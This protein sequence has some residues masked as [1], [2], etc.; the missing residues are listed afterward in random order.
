MFYLKGTRFGFPLILR[1]GV[2]KHHETY[3]IKWNRHHGAEIH[4][5]LKGHISWELAS[6]PCPLT[7]MG[8][9]FTVIT[10][11]EKHRGLADSGTPSARLGLI[12][13]SPHPGLAQGSPFS[14]DDVARLYSVLTEKGNEVRRMSSRL[15]T[16]VR[17]ISEHLT[18][19]AIH[20]P[21]GRLHLRTIASALLDETFR[22]LADESPLTL[23]G[24]VM[25][26]I[27]KWID[28]HCCEDIGLDTLI[29]LSGYGRSRFFTLFLETTGMT[30]NDYLIR[31]RIGQAKKHLTASSTLPISTIA[32]LTG[33]KSAAAFTA[34]FRKHV[35][36]TP[37]T[38][39]KSVSP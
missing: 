30:P 26:E 34:T 12:L 4:Y 5:V 24:A 18:P 8:G 29:R 15:M 21:E 28:A 16:Y 10:P 3:P 39:R 37:R 9:Y 11:G 13:E 1:T 33:F 27:V 20:T 25:P 14:D 7:V 36:T 6:R 17:D 2:M 32:R 35:G 22:V 38:F 19:D 31:A 23:N